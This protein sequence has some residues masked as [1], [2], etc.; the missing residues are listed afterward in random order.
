MPVC[1]DVAWALRD[2][3]VLNESREKKFRRLKHVLRDPINKK[4]AAL[5][6]LFPSSTVTVERSCFLSVSQSPSP[7]RDEETARTLT[8]SED[9]SESFAAPAGLVKSVCRQ[10]TKKK[11][12]FD[13]EK[14]QKQQQVA[15]SIPKPPPLPGDTRLHLDVHFERFTQTTVK[16]KH[17]YTFF[18][19]EDFRRDEFASHCKDTHADIQGGMDGWIERRCPL[20]YMGCSFKVR[21]LDP[22]GHT[23]VFNK[24]SRSFALQST[25][26]PISGSGLETLPVKDPS[27]GGAE[28]RVLYEEVSSMVSD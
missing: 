5:P 8:D 3:A 11:G 22:V 23:V 17:M 2:Q 18:C 21:R 1:I 9:S 15:P 25:T 6:L 26:E 19:G 10:L 27:K 12:I 16:P 20:A 14:Q 28:F 13:G 7:S 24:S 4:H